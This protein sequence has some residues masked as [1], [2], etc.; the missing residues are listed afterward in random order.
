VSDRRWTD[1]P[2]TVPPAMGTAAQRAV[3]AALA[4]ASIDVVQEV[5]D[6]VLASPD[7]CGV[8]Q[9]LLR[10]ARREREFANSPAALPEDALIAARTAGVLLQ[11]AA[12]GRSRN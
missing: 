12:G 8:L 2:P 11:V 10:F 5:M 1:P 3:A 7:P 6:A 4:D 9:R